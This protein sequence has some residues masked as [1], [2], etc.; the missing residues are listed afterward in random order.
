MGANWVEQLISFLTSFGFGLLAGV[1]ALLIL[2]RARPLE[3]A[4][5]DFTA[6]AL[7]I[8]AFVLSAEIGCDGKFAF[9]NLLAFIAGLIVIPLFARKLAFILK[10]RA[11]AKRPE[12]RALRLGKRRNY[13]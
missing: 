5:T 13:S 12:R 2:R 11:G 7:I 4:L 1:P 3:R 9:Y 10:K 8:A 6:C